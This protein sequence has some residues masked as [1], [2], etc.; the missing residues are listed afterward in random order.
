[1]KNMQW[2]RKKIVIVASVLAALIISAVLLSIRGNVLITTI[3]DYAQVT[4][5]GKGPM[6]NGSFNVDAGEHEVFMKADGFSDRKITITVRKDETFERTYCLVPN[7]AKGEE[8]KKNHADLILKCEG[9]AGVEYQENVDK[10]VQK[11]P[12]ISV[13]PYRSATYQIGTGASKKF[14]DDPTMSAIYIYYDDEAAKMKAE[15]WLLTQNVDLREKE[16][17][18]T[19]NEPKGA[20]ESE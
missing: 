13:L 8:W 5:D 19:Q 12:V 1:M 18:Y 4:V 17:I 14:P 6:L 20:G 7:G 15:N 2:T 10:A 16:I 11:N 3:P 9:L